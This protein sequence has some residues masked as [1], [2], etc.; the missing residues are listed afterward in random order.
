MRKNSYCAHTWYKWNSV[1]Y[2]GLKY[3]GEKQR[4]PNKNR[5]IPSNLLLYLDSKNKKGPPVQDW[6]PFHKAPDKVYQLKYF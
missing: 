3:E 5:G 2:I 4:F 1:K 6:I